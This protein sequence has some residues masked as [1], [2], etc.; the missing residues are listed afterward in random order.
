[1]TEFPSIMAMTPGA[2]PLKAKKR[3]NG[4]GMIQPPVMPTRSST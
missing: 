4:F 3:I 2:K 1:M